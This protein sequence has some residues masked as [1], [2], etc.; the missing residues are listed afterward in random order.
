MHVGCR[1]RIVCRRVCFLGLV[2]IR[3]VPRFCLLRPSALS[4][5]HKACTVAGVA[6]APAL[7]LAATAAEGFLCGGFRQLATIDLGLVTNEDTA[8]IMTSM[9]RAA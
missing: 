9:G 3:P 2:W 5:R 8:E 7:A 1:G 4:T 6:P